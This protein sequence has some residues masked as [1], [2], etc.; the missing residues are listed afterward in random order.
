M[1]QY[2]GVHMQST[3]TLPGAKTLAQITDISANAKRRLKW[4]DW[5]EAHGNNARLTCRHF[6]ISPDTLYLW[7]R[8][9]K[10]GKLQTLES[11]ST[12]PKRVRQ[13]TIPHHI[14]ELVIKLR[15][16]IQDCPNTNYSNC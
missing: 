16:Q 4:M 14:V 1:K 13:S 11:R 3:K 6:G 8:R 2:T 9:Y 7:K 5:Y 10:P 15:K 12:R